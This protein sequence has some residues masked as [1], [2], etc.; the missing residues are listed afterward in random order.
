MM[1]KSPEFSPELIERAVRMVFYAKAQYPSQWAANDPIAGKIGC[2]AEI[3]RKWVRKGE[4]DGG[5]RP[6]ST[7]AEQ[8]RLFKGGVREAIAGSRAA[9]A[10]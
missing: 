4:R 9:L 10:R 3:L 6:G 7:T 5:L 1:R 8:A 2:T